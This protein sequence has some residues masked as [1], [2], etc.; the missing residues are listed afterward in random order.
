[1]KLEE[2]FKAMFTITDT[3]NKGYLTPDEV[4]GFYQT[5]FGHDIDADIVR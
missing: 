4:S 5:L 3:K 2:D 1:M